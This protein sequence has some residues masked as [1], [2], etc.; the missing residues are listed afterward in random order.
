MKQQTVIEIFD[1]D[2]PPSMEIMTFL[3][4]YAKTH[5]ISTEQMACIITG[6]L[7]S[8]TMNIRMHKA[9]QERVHGSE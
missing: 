4:T 1:E 3:E 8:L 5:A 9:Y 2:I 7:A 6:I